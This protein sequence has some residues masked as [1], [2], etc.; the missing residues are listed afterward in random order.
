MAHIEENYGADP[1]YLWAKYPNF[2]VF[3]N[4]ANKKWFAVF[5]DVPKSLLGLGGDQKI[6]ILNVK[7][8]PIM[9]GSLLEEK[10]FLP[11]YHMNKASWISICLDES[12]PDDKIFFLLE[13]SHSLT[14]RK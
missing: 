9:L 1:E 5:M 4:R 13:M 8:D 3:R 2:S 6:W 12:V 10:G 7:C 11:G 14:G